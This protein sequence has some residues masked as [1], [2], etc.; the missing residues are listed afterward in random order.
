MATLYAY[1]IPTMDVRDGKVRLAFDIARYK[2]DMRTKLSKELEEYRIGSFVDVVGLDSY[3]DMIRVNDK[4]I[5]P[6]AKTHARFEKEL[7]EKLN[8]GY[9]TYGKKEE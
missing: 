2:R 3:K 6:D 9:K 7:V 8:W 5:S 4:L 1:L